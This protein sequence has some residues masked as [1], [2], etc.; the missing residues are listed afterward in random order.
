[1]AY[2]DKT[3]E[4]VECGAGFTFSASEQEFYS[5][6][7]FVNEPKRCQQCRQAKKMER[8]GG[9]R[10]PREM[11]AAICAGCGTQ[12]EVPFEP[13]DGRPVYCSDCFTSRR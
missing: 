5:S 2:E 1:M 7:G 13:R 11:H 6:K 10:R 4:C 3:L 12:C 8:G 9:A